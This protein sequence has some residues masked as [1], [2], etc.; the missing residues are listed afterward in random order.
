MTQSKQLQWLYESLTQRKR[1][2][3]VADN[4]LVLL[5]NQLTQVEQSY[6]QKAAKG[7]LRQKFFGYTSMLQ[8]F[9][10]PVGLQR[11]V[12]KAME[13]FTTAYPLDTQACDRP[14]AVEQFIR[15]ISQEL[16]K[17]F[18]NNDFKMDRLNRQVRHERGMDISN[19]ASRS[20]FIGDGPMSGG[21]GG[22][23]EGAL[24]DRRDGGV[25]VSG[26][27][28][29]WVRLRVAGKSSL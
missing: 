19:N 17:P 15:H 5:R 28:G 12:N 23:E 14:D 7:S 27:L 21:G 11:Q 9:A 20:G 2:E 29:V 22:Q 6:L 16:H 24:E 8:D 4:I 1:P 25:F 18:G 13:L 26:H 3:D 10:K